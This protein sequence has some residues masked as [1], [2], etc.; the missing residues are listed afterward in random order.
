MRY[1]VV[2]FGIAVFSL[3]VSGTRGGNGG[4]VPSNPN[5]ASVPREFQYIPAPP[6]IQ[7]MMAPSQMPLNYIS[8]RPG[9]YSAQDWRAVIDSTWGPGV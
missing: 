1:Q 9:H 2:L 4:E 7:R 3:G 8:K 5:H 6:E